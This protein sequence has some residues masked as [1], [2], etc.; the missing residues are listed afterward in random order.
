MAIGEVNGARYMEQRGLIQFPT[1]FPVESIAEAPERPRPEPE[2]EP[3][4]VPA[5]MGLPEILAQ[6]REYRADEALAQQKLDGIRAG[7]SRLEQLITERVGE[8]WSL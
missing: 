5:E 4:P 8:G 1:R 7:R 6:L 2:P 3:E